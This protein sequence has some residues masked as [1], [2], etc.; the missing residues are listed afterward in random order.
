LALLSDEPA[1]GKTRVLD[2]LGLLAASPEQ[3]ID[4]TG[5]V[6]FVLI[7]ESS[8]TIL[9]DETDMIF[10]RSGSSA[11]GQVLA[12]LNSGYRQGSTVPRARKDSVER[13]P[14]FCPVAFAGLGRLPDTLMTRS[15]VVRMRPRKP[16]ER[17]DAYQPRIHGPIGQTIGQALGSWMTSVVG[18]LASA[19]P[20]LPDGVQDRQ[21][22][23]WESLLAIGELAG[24]RWP[25]RAR[26]ACEAFV[27]GANTG[28]PVTP[29]GLALLDD[30]RR[31][32]PAGQSKIA[33][34]GLVKLLADVP[35]TD[36]TWD[37][38]TAPRELAAMLRPHNIFP[39]KIRQGERTCQGYV[40]S[41]I[42]G[43]REQTRTGAA[44]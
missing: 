21:A 44:A 33:T 36:R 9:M 6:V 22:E 14:V 42:P 29:P 12:V 32:W 34:A 10:G 13:F 41:D 31:V 20:T 40:A 11:K 8:P 27:L 38:A 17:C 26:A 30:I 16:G 5:P 1:S 25:E 39:G 2:L 28:K 23:V 19:W 35:G 3:V 43:L 15:V 24:G 7:K 37:P 18:E 4:P